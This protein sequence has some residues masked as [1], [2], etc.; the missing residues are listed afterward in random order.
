LNKRRW[1]NFNISTGRDPIPDQQ[2]L[3]ALSLGFALAISPHVEHLPWWLSLFVLVIFLWRMW[4]MKRASAV[5]VFALRLLLLVGLC[6]SLFQYYGT[7]LGRDA[8]VALLVGLSALK[9]LEIRSFRDCMIVVF[10]CF[11]VVLTSFL[12]SQS[13]L[14]GIYLLVIVVILTAVML[15]LNHS[16]RSRLVVML[17]R[18]AMLIA[19]ALPIG[20]VLFLLFPRVPIGLFGLPG[21]SHAG[22]TGMSDVIRPGS[23]NRLNESDE[24]AFRADIEGRLPDMKQ[25]YWRGIVLGEYKD[26]SWRQHKSY[27]MTL[28]SKL[29]EFEPDD[30]LQYSLLLEP[31]N[32]RWVF[33]LDLPV[34]KPDT[35]RWGRGQTLVSMSPIVE[36]RRVELASA[37][38]ARYTALTE[39]EF[40]RY[41]ELPKQVK[42]SL[43]ELAIE[44]N[45]HA[46]SPRVVIGRV[47]DFYR[48][49]GFTYTLQPPRLGKAPMRQFLLETRKGYC[50]HYASAFTL[51]MRLNGLPARMVAG[52]QGGE[53]NPQGEYLIVRQSDAHA[54]SEVWLEDE[55]WIRVDPTAVVAPERIEFG[56]EALRLLLE[57]G[58]VLGSLSTEQLQAAISRPM[59]QMI[60][61]RAIWVWDDLNTSWYLRVIGYG[62]DEQQNFLQR[63][64]LSS[65]N[66]TGL[67]IASLLIVVFVA[68][69]QSALTLL[70]GRRRRDPVVHLYQQFC[71]KLERIGMQRKQSEGPL[72]F[73]H[74]VLAS[75]PDLNSS[76]E[77]ITDLYVS[78]HYAGRRESTIMKQLKLAVK[79]F[80]PAPISK[81][82]CRQ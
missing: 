55:G 47:L 39:A 70:S 12:Y 40:E 14:L 15:Y 49:E 79:A 48:S 1:F 21:D 41:T 24:V 13:M 50:E 64:G 17:G 5:P 2:T 22:M 74:R 80:R 63:L 75:R 56:L 20:L 19:L 42:Q 3:I 52:Y 23:I 36:R 54:W 77:Q 46:D 28:R 45:Q 58:Q 71:N 4:I 65:L 34:N 18:S 29:P 9:F 67:L 27:I 57:R 51:L 43:G 16:D 78:I 7:L 59:L 60:W 26:N 37:P 25:R 30:V 81:S 38:N 44:I 6:Y 10:L 73:S 82:E 31:S 33:S 32:K 69:L 62:K 72:D 53:W 11:M 68:V 61:N 66:W 76:V 8:G 35:L